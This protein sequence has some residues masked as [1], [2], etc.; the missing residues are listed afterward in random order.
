MRSIVER[1]HGT[2]GGYT[3]HTCRCEPCR[4]AAAEHA[5]TYRAANREKRT[6]YQAKWR[7]ANPERSREIAARSRERRRHVKRAKNIEFYAD[8]SYRSWMYGLPIGRL[9]EMLDEQG[10]ACAICRSGFDEASPHVDHDHA[11]CAGRR[12]CGKCVRGL[13]CKACNDGLG[14]FRDD[15]A[16][17][18]RAVD[19][20]SGGDANDTRS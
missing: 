6:A 17:L 12:S 20:L 15:P 14:R 5:R 13:L 10:N 16:R 9:Q 1:W 3:N 4:T 18:L 19:Y 2:L 7:T 11:C 8:G